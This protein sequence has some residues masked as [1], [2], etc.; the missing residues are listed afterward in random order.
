MPGVRPKGA[1]GPES[2]PEEEQFIVSKCNSVR[3]G[4]V[5]WYSGTNSKKIHQK[6]CTK[7]WSIQ[8]GYHYHK[9]WFTMHRLMNQFECVRWI[10]ITLA[11]SL[12]GTIFSEASLSVSTVLFIKILGPWITIYYQII[13]SV[14][15][16]FS[17]IQPFFSIRPIFE[18]DYQDFRVAAFDEIRTAD[19]FKVRRVE[20]VFIRGEYS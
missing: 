4:T 14:F 10:L 19:S 9:L 15:L 1:N 11:S 12:V 8:T 13:I 6:P 5:T 7:A 2:S 17:F 20:C 16:N 18:F 3:D